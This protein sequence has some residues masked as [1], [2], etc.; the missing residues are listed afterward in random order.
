MGPFLGV[1]SLLN[2]ERHLGID[3]TE[4]RLHGHAKELAAE[5]ERTERERKK[6]TLEEPLRLRSIQRDPMTVDT[7]HGTNPDEFE[8]GPKR[9]SILWRTLCG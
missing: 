4:R 7:Y 6:Q 8:R 5:A 1:S 3:V 9:A 2:L